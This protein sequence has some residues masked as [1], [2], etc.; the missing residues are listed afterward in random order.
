MTFARVVVA[1]RFAQLVAHVFAHVALDGQPG[2]LHD[3]RYVAWAR[4]R[5][6][7]DARGL[8][9]HDATLIGE[10]WRSDR[11]LDV[12]HGVFELQRDVDEFRRT[13]ARTLT[14]L[15][16]HE[17][18]SPTLLALLR[19]PAI[20]PVAELLHTTL[21]LLVDEFALVLAGLAPQLESARAQVAPLVDRLAAI[22]PGLEHAR[23]ELVWALGVHGRAFSDRILVG[24]PTAWSG[25]S[26]ARQAV[27]AAHE[28]CVRA[29]LAADYLDSEWHA[30]VRL[31][32]AMHHAD[33]PE[34]RDA[35]ARWLAELDL[36]ELLSG[37]VA[38][39]WLAH[40]E[41]GGLLDDPR[42]RAGR[43]ACSIA[44]RRWQSIS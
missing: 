16:A 5:I 8:L 7:T 25:C 9:E 23:I 38:R 43:L 24:A 40:D 4:E 35:H 22:V 39:G 1:D 34:L 20:A 6:T 21:A 14:E 17:V 42:G 44:L 19:D 27:L 18:R 37:V 3:A 2:N 11:R 13:C 31:A 32:R 26:A 41:A 33:D 12:L 29:S 36:D 30:L 10:R 15:D 28:H